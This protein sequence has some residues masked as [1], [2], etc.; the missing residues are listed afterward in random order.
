MKLKKRNH[1]SFEEKLEGFGERAERL[2]Q[3]PHLD[4]G[5][6]WWC[7]CLE[8]GKRYV[9]GAFNSEDEAYS[10]GYAKIDGDFEVI[11]L[12]TRDTATATQQLK[13]RSMRKDRTLQETTRRARHAGRGVDY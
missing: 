5:V 13:A 6:Y 4:T 10:V 3:Q 9:L 1:S 11:A 7:S 12:R 8:E 2:Q